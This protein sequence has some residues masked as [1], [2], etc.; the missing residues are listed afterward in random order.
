[1]TDA[2][3][4]ELKQFDKE[5]ALPAWDGLISRQQS[6]LETLGV[7]TMFPT[8]KETDRQVRKHCIVCAPVE[9]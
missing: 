8:S 2:F 9:F 7:P 5:R 3:C 6:T 4:R 1:M